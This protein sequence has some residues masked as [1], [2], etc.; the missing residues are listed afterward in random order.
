V[1]T[2]Q[3]AKAGKLVSVICRHAALEQKG[4]N[5]EQ[6]HL[7]TR[8]KAKTEQ[9]YIVFDAFLSKNKQCHIL[10]QKDVKKKK[11][12]RF[13]SAGTMHISQEI[14]QTNYKKQFSSSI[15]HE[16]AIL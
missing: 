2:L 10:L 11:G 6:V 4:A 5:S 9:K 13:N 15:L 14:S 8:K 3:G 1:H 12:K 7:R 16:I